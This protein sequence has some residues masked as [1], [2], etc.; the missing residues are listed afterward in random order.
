L[1][2]VAFSLT[3]LA[4][5]GNLPS[6]GRSSSDRRFEKLPGEGAIWDA[7][8][9]EKGLK[10]SLSGNPHEHTGGATLAPHWRAALV[11]RLRLAR[12]ISGTRTAL[13]ACERIPHRPSRHDG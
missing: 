12:G 10:G 7:P 6:P 13:T 5:L 9:T 1:R 2:P 4:S 3:P 8:T 11:L